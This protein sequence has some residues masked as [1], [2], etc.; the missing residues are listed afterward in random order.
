MPTK[1]KDKRHKKD[2]FM[3]LHLLHK[4]NKIILK[5][6]SKSKTKITS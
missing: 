2:C 1:N 3:Q 4:E 6:N 5:E